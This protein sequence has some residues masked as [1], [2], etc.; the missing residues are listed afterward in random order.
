[1]ADVHPAPLLALML[2][3]GCA[4]STA[5]RSRRAFQ[6]VIRNR[7]RAERMIHPNAVVAIFQG[8]IRQA[9]NGD[10]GGQFHA[11]YFIIWGARRSP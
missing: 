4:G 1:M 6:V 5:E 8:R 7:S 11:I 10:F 3:G 9:L 2:V